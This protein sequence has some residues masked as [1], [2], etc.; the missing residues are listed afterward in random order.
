MFHQSITDQT[1]RFKSTHNKDQ[2]IKVLKKRV[3]NYFKENNISTYA[4]GAMWLKVCFAF[5][6]WIGVYSLII[7]DKL[8]AYPLLLIVVF[9]LLGFCNIFV[10]FACVHDSV[11]DALSPKP[12]VN[13]L[14]ARTFDFVGGNSYLLR[15]MHGEHHKWVNI[16]GIDVTLETHG[17]F[18]FTPHEPWKPIHRFQ[19]LYTPILYLMAQLHWV[20]AKDFKWFFGESHIGNRKNVKHP[21]KE[22]LVLLFFK[23]NYYTLTLVLPMIFLSAPWWLILIAWV[24]MHIPSGLAFVLIFQCTHVYDGTTY[25]MP[26]GEGNIENNY[27]LHILD[28][29]AD[30]SRKSYIGTW[31]MGAINVHVIH[32]IFPNIC[33]IHYQKITPIIIETAKEFGIKY[34]E[35]QTFPEALAAHMRMLKHL[36]RADA[37]VPAYNETTVRAVETMAA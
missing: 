11:H 32:H 20:S 16:H 25:P 21:L 17:M 12:W 33:H 13:K 19:H 30:F 23:A 4:N 36:S 27:A 22:Y 26:D 34:K 5:A 10:A 14:L 7:S 8:S 1:V 18:R 28:T 35:Y 24:L 31:L 37:V 2:F 9:S 15:Q 6:A 3:D 29:T